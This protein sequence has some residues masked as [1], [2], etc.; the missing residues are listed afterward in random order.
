MCPWPRVAFL[1]VNLL[2]LSGSLRHVHTPNCSIIHCEVG[3]KLLTK[4]P[5]AA[6]L[7]L[8]RACSARCLIRRSSA[9]GSPGHLTCFT[10]RHVGDEEER[11]VLHFFA[12]AQQM[13]S[14]V[15]GALLLKTPGESGGSP[16][17]ELPIPTTKSAA[18]CTCLSRSFRSNSPQLPRGDLKI[19]NSGKISHP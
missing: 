1:N 15:G 11:R 2:S 10:A 3:L 6:D 7:C 16:W 19:I 14:K 18:Q 4:T 9:L 8:L 17:C 13:A 5:C 12:S